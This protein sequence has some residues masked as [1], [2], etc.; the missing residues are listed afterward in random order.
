MAEILKPELYGEYEDFVKSHPM[1]SITQSVLWHGVKNNW[2][3]AVVV[4]RDAS[5]GIVG[6]VSILMQKVPFFNASFL[7]APRGPVCDLY[8]REVMDDLMLGVDSLASKHRAYTY[9]IDPDVHQSD[10]R[11]LSLMHS[12]GFVQNKGGDGFETIQARFNYR[13]YLKGRGEEAL[14]MNLAQKTRYNIRVALKHNVEVKVCGKE[15][16]DDFLRIMKATGERDGFATRP[17]AYFERMIDGLCDHCRLYM[18]YYEGR[19]VAG[20]ISTNYAGKTC[21]IYGASDNAHRNVM[22]PY[23]L[24][25]EM[26]KW[27]LE[28]G[29]TVYDFQGVSGNIE[30]KS[31][32]LYGI[33]RFK[34]GFNGTLDELCGEFDRK[35]RPLTERLVDKAID[36]SEWL[37]VLKRKLKT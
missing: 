4:S 35:Y 8:D 26:I 7:Y 18:A 16:L 1:G 29:C 5:G 6:G 14:F 28:T 31:N 9:K 33:Y 23:L 24:Q 19:P 15:S 21:Y 3:H 2:G 34:K 32:P 30:D 27:A 13:L 37:R 11:F 22:A 12:M 36:I 17:K 20:A 10:A 25:W